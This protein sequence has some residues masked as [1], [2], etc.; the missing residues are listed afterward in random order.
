MEAAAR[1]IELDLSAATAVVQGFGNVG[2]NAARIFH[3]LGVRVTGVSDVSGGLHKPNGLD[4]PAVMEHVH[5]QGTLEGYSEADHVSNEELLELDVDLLLPSAVENVITAENADRIKAPC[6]VE[7][8]NGPVTSAADIILRDNGKLVVPD[9]LANAG[10]VTVSYFE[11]VQNRSGLAWEL[12]EVH[13]RLERIMR[14]EF[15]AI[16]SLMEEIGSDMRTAAYVHALKRLAT[17]IE[18]AGTRG[19]FQESN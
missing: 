14:R 2:G 7:L 17:A 19:W 11:W 18:A 4:I 10:G 8:A 12:D 16:Y 13:S 9:I 15:D 1:K 6:I 3:D 5:D